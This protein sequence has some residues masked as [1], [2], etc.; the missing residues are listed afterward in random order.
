MRNTNAGRAI[1]VGGS[2]AGIMDFTAATVFYGVWRGISPIQVW[3]SVA[4]GL[5]GM[6]AYDGGLAT[7]V[8]GV[9][10]HFLIALTAAIT[11]YAASR[12]IS[13]LVQHP[14][15]S[16]VLYGV[17]VFFFMQIVVLPLSAFPH[18][19]AFP[20]IGVIRGSI[21]HIVCVGLPIALSTYN[22]SSDHHAASPRHGIV[23]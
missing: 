22:F 13:L 8:L 23:L 16:G 4:S 12:K 20:L 11:F 9:F 15:I 7:A 10:F 17:A 1:L 18:P 5:L 14:I 2:L 21:I 3:Q 6:S 19:I